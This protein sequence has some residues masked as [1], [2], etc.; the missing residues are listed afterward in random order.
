[1]SHTP[2][3]WHTHRA[4]SRSKLSIRSDRGVY[5]VQGIYGDDEDANARLIAASKREAMDR[6]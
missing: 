3:P 6:R 2:G 4:Q 1:M 5:V